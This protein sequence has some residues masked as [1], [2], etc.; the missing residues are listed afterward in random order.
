MPDI[1]DWQ[2]IEITFSIRQMIDGIKD[3]GFSN[4]VFTYETIDFSIEF[5]GNFREIFII[6]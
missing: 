3:I 5:E 2:G 6:E 1:L 4:A